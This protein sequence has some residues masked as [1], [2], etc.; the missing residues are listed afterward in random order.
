MKRMFLSL[1]VVSLVLMMCFA[2]SSCD[3]GGCPHDFENACDPECS[4]CG[5][6][7]TTTHV[8][9]EADCFRAKTCRNCDHVEG[10]PLGHNVDFTQARSLDPQV[11]DHC[12]LMVFPDNHTEPYHE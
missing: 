6:E 2:L 5:Y 10:E 7:R 8:F 1:T 12:H 3:E 4:L 11:C 9:E